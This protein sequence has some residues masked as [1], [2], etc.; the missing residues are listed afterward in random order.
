M[1]KFSL[2]LVSVI[3]ASFIS[4]DTM[5]MQPRNERHQG[6]ERQPRHHNRNNHNN[7]GSVEAPLDGSVLALLGAAGVIY[8]FV[9]KKKKSIEA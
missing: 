1:K 3:L 8:Y 5:A 6:H 2:F 7:P 4:I 9:R